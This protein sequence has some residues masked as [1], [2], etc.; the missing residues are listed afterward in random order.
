MLNNIIQQQNSKA[1]K[2]FCTFILYI[3]YKKLFLQP[4]KEK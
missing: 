1:N 3:S 4:Y 2:L